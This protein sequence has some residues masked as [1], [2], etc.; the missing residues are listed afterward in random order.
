MSSSSQTEEQAMASPDMDIRPPHKV[1][2][3]LTARQE[4]RLINFLEDKFLELTR[5][6]KKRSEPTTHLPTL[7]LY[8]EAAQK[9]L[10]MVLQI[11][12]VDP[13]TSLRTAYLLRLTNDVLASVPGY[14]ADGSNIPI[15]LDWL[16]DLDQAW[17]MILQAQVWD[18]ENGPAD[19]VIDAED[20]ATGTR[21][22][23]VTQTER[24]RLRSLLIGGSATLEEW[25]AGAAPPPPDTIHEEDEDEDADDAG[26]L[27]DVQDMLEEL[28]VQDGFNELFWR[29]LQ[30]LGLGGDFVLP[31]D[32]SVT[33]VSMN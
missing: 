29:T 32:E 22:S 8:L 20:A 12:P 11:P 7:P 33:E 27:N 6:Y 30:E 28:G 24:T 17:L 5:G 18:P 25:L 9:I 16:D 19:L 3:A 2:R 21:S 13:S 1:L 31:S 15:L 14:P 4:R 23:P 26:P 10:A